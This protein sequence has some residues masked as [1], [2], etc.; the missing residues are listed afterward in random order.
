MRLWRLRLT[1]V[2]ILIGLWYLLLVP[3][4][5]PGAAD[6]LRVPQVVVWLDH[7]ADLIILRL[8]VHCCRVV[9]AR[10]LVEL[11]GD[12]QIPILLP[13]VV[14]KQRPLRRLLIAALR[15]RHRSDHALL[16]LQ[17]LLHERRL[18]FC[19]IGRCQVL[20]LCTTDAGAGLAHDLLDRHVQLPELRA[21]L[22]VLERIL[23]H[24]LT[25]LQLR[26]RRSAI[27]LR[28]DH[29]GVFE[30]VRLHVLLIAQL[31]HSLLHLRPLVQTQLG[32][33]HPV[34]CCLVGRLKAWHHLRLSFL[35]G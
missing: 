32:R 24:V 4:A 28:L 19:L 2:I 1:D 12:R 33:S 22:T 3:P 25:G 21:H 20:Q 34:L 5:Q 13:P 16:V 11:A 8:R 15:H 7:G 9:R 18:Q 17:L 30:I 29:V 27:L 31:S 26:L 35:L 14:V 6:N 23:A 10:E